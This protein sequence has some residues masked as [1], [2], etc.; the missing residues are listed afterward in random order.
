MK[1]ILIIV[2]LLII[3]NI[4]KLNASTGLLKSATIIECDGELY[5]THSSDNHYHKAE[6]TEDGKY[7]AVGDSLGTKWTCKGILK[8][9]NENK[10]LEKISVTFD[11]CV[12]GDTANF[13]VNNEKVK[14]RF[15]AI[16]TP[17]TVHPT[18]EV[19]EYGKNASE[20]TCN[21]LK[22]AQKIEIEYEE[23]KIDKYGRNLGWIWTDGTLI[24]EELV[25]VGYAEVAYIYG[26]YKYTMRLC[27]TQKNAI[28]S[29]KGMWNDIK[30][31]EGYCS[32]LRKVERQN[33]NINTE[34]DSNK[35]DIPYETVGVIVIIIVGIIIKTFK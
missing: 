13:I 30:K 4:D 28:E 15:L 27:E 21:K 35:K 34:N 20:Y 14:F 2:C 16:D 32:T 17:E 5:G 6:E 3:I 7:K 22:N 18:K 9:P 23:S 1:K 31:E 25:S 33:T 11:S 19:E 26:N 29:N 8:K 24:Q 12:D 10:E